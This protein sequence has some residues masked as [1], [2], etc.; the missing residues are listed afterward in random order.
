MTSFDLEHFNKDHF[1]L[2]GLARQQGLDEIELERVYQDIQSRVH[3]DKHAH[4]G[5]SERRLAMQWATRVNEAYLTL[6]SPLK[7]AEYLL[8]LV[9]HDPE[10][11]RNTAMPMDFLVQQMEWRENV[12]QASHAADIDRLE[13][14]DRSL[15]A[16]MA[17]QYGALGGALDTNQDYPLAAQIVRQLMFKEKL[18]HEIDDALAA[19]EA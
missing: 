11:E 4:L 3:P 16:E 7:R 18:L 10:I 19:A 12:E 5:E 9:G 15:R 2:L 13:A 8:R 17:G 6:K 1:E 14:F